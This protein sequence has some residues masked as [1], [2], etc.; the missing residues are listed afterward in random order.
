MCVHPEWGAGRDWHLLLQQTDPADHE[1]RGFD[2][3]TPSRLCV[4]RYAGQIQLRYAGQIREITITNTHFKNHK[5]SGFNGR[6]PSTKRVQLQI[7]KIHNRYTIFR[8]VATVSLETFPYLK[9]KMKFIWLLS[10]SLHYQMT[11]PFF[12]TFYVIIHGTILVNFVILSSL[13]F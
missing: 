13:P 1:S 10:P 4:S 2:G 7:T 11:F 3:R 6:T 12:C 9:I 5:S 8:R